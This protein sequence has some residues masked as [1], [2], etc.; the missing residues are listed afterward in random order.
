MDP[1]RQNQTT[2][3]REPS[4]VPSSINSPGDDIIGN[5]QRQKFQTE[6]NNWV[7]N[8]SGLAIVLGWF[9][10]LIA[11]LLVFLSYMSFHRHT[12]A[13][14][15]FYEDIVLTLL[16]FILSVVF[17]LVGRDLKRP[18]VDVPTAKRDLCLISGLVV[19]ITIINIV[20]AHQPMSAVALLLLIMCIRTLIAINRA[21]KN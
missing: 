15:S 20:V 7:K 14:G 18:D 4:I 3:N 1:D 2:E 8:T 10:I 17:I 13:Q 9:S 11:V 19:F 5:A 21:I 6:A 12:I 16:S